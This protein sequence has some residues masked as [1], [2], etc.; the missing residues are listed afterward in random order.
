MK[1]K[2]SALLLA[3]VLCLL[4]TACAQEPS[5]PG[6]YPM[7]FIFSSGAG[8][9]RTVLTLNADGTFT[10]Q[11]SDSNMGE[12]GADHPN[13]TV[14]LCSFS[15]RF[16]LPEQLN[17]HSYSLTLEEVTSHRPGGE[18]WIDSGI[19]YV[20]AGPYGLY[21]DY[22]DGAM[23]RSFMLY[24]PATPV[25]DLDE[26]LLSWW[27]ARFEPVPPETLSCWA[28]WNVDAG[29]AFFTDPQIAN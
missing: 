2:L 28:L 11:Y 7:E 10:G 15:G 21:N 20:S 8:A 16:S 19:L 14:Y 23:S 18:E 13:G 4:P 6:E 3:A 22:T 26:T 25:S 17:V 12:T 24:D 1:K 5:L 9:W 27:P 29:T